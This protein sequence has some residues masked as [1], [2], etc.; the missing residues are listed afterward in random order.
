MP[1]TVEHV[2]AKDGTSI[3]VRHWTVE[4]GTAW[5]TLMIVHGLA[6]HSG[7]YEHVGAHLAGAGIDTYGI[8]L[9]GFGGSGGPRA[10]VDR[11]SHFHDDLE[12]RITALRAAAPDRP[13]VLYG[14][15]VGGLVALGYV[16]DGRARPD[17]LVLSAP[18]ISAAL[19]AWQR[20]L[21]GI[22][23]RVAPKA[24]I[25]NR[26]SG[27][28]LSSDPAVGVAYF[29]DPLNVH[30]SSARFGVLAFEEQRRVSAA[31]DRLT[32]P[33]LVIHGGEDRLVPTATSEALLGRPGVTRRVFD[34]LRHE[35][36]NEPAYPDVLDHVVAWIRGR[37]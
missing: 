35:V 20:A 3:L 33:T 30:H 27:S 23:G 1:S 34:G 4:S 9:R 11:W 36:H 29:A 13:L 15:S 17:L 6:E 14:H 21:V 22:L 5:A 18:A 2:A 7:R 12:E 25:S 16:L 10:S 37:V 31:L 8:D 28:Q 32:I 26:L 24:M 19:P